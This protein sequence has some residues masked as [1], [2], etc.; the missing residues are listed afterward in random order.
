MTA[1]WTTGHGAILKSIN[2]A[3]SPCRETR[4]E[5][6]DRA[7]PPASAEGLRGPCMGNTLELGMCGP[8]TRHMSALPRALLRGC[9][10]T[11]PGLYLHV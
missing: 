6:P 7:R 2:L 9:F 1:T 3:F 8:G 4:A 11:L 5:A 10:R